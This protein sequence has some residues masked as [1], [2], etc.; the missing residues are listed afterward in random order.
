MKYTDMSKVN[1]QEYSVKDML[2]KV[3]FLLT[4]NIFYTFSS[5]SIVCFEQVNVCWDG[6]SKIN[7]DQSSNNLGF[8][9]INSKVWRF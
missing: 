1:F 8:N 6:N 9:C 4:L 3:S 5:V 7:F 2:V